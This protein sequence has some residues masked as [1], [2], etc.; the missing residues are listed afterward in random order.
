MDYI[1]QMFWAV[2]RKAPRLGWPLAGHESTA[3]YKVLFVLI[4]VRKV[5]QVKKESLYKGNKGT[6]ER[7]ANFRKFHVVQNV[8]S[9]DQER[10]MRLNAVLR[11][12]GAF[13]A[14]MRTWISFCRL[15]GTM[16]RFLAREQHNKRGTL[17]CLFWSQC[18]GLMRAR[19][20]RR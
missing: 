8:R 1:H 16:E 3:F 7:V 6:E 13:Y 2:I 4:F 12:W 20:D 18:K 10:Q 11:S 5:R 17:V 15:G 19:Q 9:T 14:I